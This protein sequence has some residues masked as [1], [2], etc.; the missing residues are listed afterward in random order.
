MG[1]PLTFIT[2]NVKIS[3]YQCRYR[4]NRA[5]TDQL[6][7]TI[8]NSFIKKKYVTVIIFGIEKSFDTSW[9]H[10]ILKDLHSMG[11]R[12]LLPNFIENFLN[13]FKQK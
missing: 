6:N 3:K 1:A 7:K 9:K 8:R 2:I 10:G 13:N 4:K 12:G 11:L 5:T